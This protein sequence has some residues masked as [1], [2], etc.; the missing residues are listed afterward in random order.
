MA[1][2]WSGACDFCGASLELKA[3]FGGFLMR[4]PN[5]MNVPH[6]VVQTYTT[7]DTTPNYPAQDAERTP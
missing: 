4:C 7:S 6:P 2:I 3:T 5:Q 1:D